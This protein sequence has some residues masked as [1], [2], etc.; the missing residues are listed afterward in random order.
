[1]LLTLHSL[2][3][4]QN[5]FASAKFWLS[6]SF[7]LQKV[8]FLIY[9]HTLFSSCTSD[10]FLG[11]KM[12][13]INCHF[14]WTFPGFQHHVFYVLARKK[15]NKCLQFEYLVKN[16]TSFSFFLPAHNCSVGIIICVFIDRN[17]NNKN[18]YRLHRKK[19]INVHFSFNFDNETKMCE[20]IW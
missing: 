20:T 11:T 12:L 5:A 4:T 1:M 14:T 17:A 8:V 15:S 13:H 3:K 18:P 7:A 2:K 10:D 19:D 16:F 9:G 6:N